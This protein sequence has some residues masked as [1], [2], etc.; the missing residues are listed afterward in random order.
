MK[1]RQIEQH[2]ERRRSLVDLNLL[3]E[4]KARA[5]TGARGCASLLGRVLIDAALVVLLA[6]GLS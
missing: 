5:R 4:A 3:G 2:V 6:A 1:R